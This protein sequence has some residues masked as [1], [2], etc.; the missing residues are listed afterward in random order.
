LT[1]NA[2]RFEHRVQASAVQPAVLA[3]IERLIGRPFSFDACA[4]RVGFG[5]HCNL[6]SPSNRAVDSAALE[7]HTVWFTPRSRSH[8]RAFMEQYR[9]CKQR[10]PDTALALLVPASVAEQEATLLQGMRRVHRFSPGMTLFNTLDL[11]GQPVAVPPV[12][13]GAE[14]WY[15]PP[16]AGPPPSTPVASA[17]TLPV[18]AALAS[19]RVASG[20]GVCRGFG[21][22]HP[23]RYR[24]QPRF[25]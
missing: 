25:R 3:A 14:V 12:P 4:L 11:V 15:D 5:D 18:A 17:L 21:A 20:L 24:S 13:V 8:F 22:D 23:C 7:G 1:E 16:A 9:A 2:F 10:R 19:W 6:L